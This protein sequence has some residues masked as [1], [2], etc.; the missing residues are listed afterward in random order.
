MKYKTVPLIILSAILVSCTTNQSFEENLKKTLNEKPEIITKLIE[1]N[2]GKFISA[3]Q[4]AA[5]KGQA[6]LAQKRQLD[7]KK[8]L[9][10]SFNKPLV[11]K[12][13]KD[14]LI[15]GTKGAPITIVEYSDFECPFCSRGYNTISEVLKKYDGKVQ[16][17]YKHLPL[18]FHPHA[19]V[20]SKYYEALRIQNE[21]IAIEFH[22]KVF[23]KQR[24]LKK[25]EKFLEALSKRLGANMSKLK[26]DLKSDKVKERI[27]E[28]MKEAAKFG[29]QGTPGFLINGVPLRGAY[30]L[31]KFDQ[32]IIELEKRGKLKI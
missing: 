16:F 26:K 28:D 11:P 12:I 25:G 14:E 20:A 4:S 17:I 8:Q 22:D 23:E 30:P 19:M 2:P 3:F 24:D 5:K 1:N 6:E 15:R 21:K 10:E 31:E 13:R 18:S 27:D 29:M 9:E 32:I 7:E